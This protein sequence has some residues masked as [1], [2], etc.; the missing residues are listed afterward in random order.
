MV[1]IGDASYSLYLIQGF[2][3]LMLSK[4]HFIINP[5]LRLVLAAGT[6][7]AA[8]K[9][10]KIETLLSEYCKRYLKQKF[11]ASNK[12]IFEPQN[13]ID[14]ETQRAIILCETPCRQVAL[15]FQNPPPIGI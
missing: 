1:S 13:Y 10:F 3:V 2:I 14:T 9:M 6:V 15:W 12:H 7:Y 8:L 11:I 5:L 4:E